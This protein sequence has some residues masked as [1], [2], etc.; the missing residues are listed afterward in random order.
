MSDRTCTADE[1]DRKAH[2]RGLCSMHYRRVKRSGA[3]MPPVIGTRLCEIPGCERK[4]YCRGWC[5]LH[6]RRWTHFGD[7]L[8][9]P[10]YPTPEERFWANVEKGEHCWEWTG[11]LGISG[12]GR[13]NIGRAKVVAHRL[14]YEWAKG[15]IPSGLEVDHRCHNRRCV[16]PGHL[17]AVTRKQNQEHRLG[18][19][20]IS[21]SGVRGVVRNRN[22]WATEVTH[23]GKTYTAGQFADIREAQAAVIKLR[24]RLFTHNDVDRLEPC[25]SC[26]LKRANSRSA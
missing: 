11:E 13:F 6:Y 26:G 25:S 12:Y 18:A 20:K 2:S 22:R 15:E 14:S 24:N 16:N 8:H 4:H 10:S 19:Q 5:V 9:E 1:C 17:R 21:S 23:H 3:P 7:A